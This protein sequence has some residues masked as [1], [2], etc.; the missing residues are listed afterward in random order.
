MEDLIERR[1][2]FGEQVYRQWRGTE[3]PMRREDVEARVM[4]SLCDGKDTDF[5]V[6]KNL[7]LVIKNGRAEWYIKFT[8]KLPMV[9]PLSIG[10][11]PAVIKQKPIKF[12]LANYTNDR[13]QANSITY[14]VAIQRVL[15]FQ[16]WLKNARVNL[17]DIDERKMIKIWARGSQ[18]DVA[19]LN[20]RECK[21]LKMVEQIARR[22]P[23]TIVGGESEWWFEEEELVHDDSVFEAKRIEDITEVGEDDD[24]N[25]ANPGFSE[26]GETMDTGDHIEIK[27]DGAGGKGGRNND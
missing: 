12:K 2:K 17:P 26:I 6:V 8:P 27:I 20:A 22:L 21:Y 19:S 15:D 16:D 7:H 5:A 14:D 13:S 11:A 18:A 3:P 24:G 4:A 25:P 23:E 10:L 9:V 1:R